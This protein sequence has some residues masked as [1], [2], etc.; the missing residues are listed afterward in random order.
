[1]RKFLYPL[2]ENPYRPK[3]IKSAI[4]VLKSCKLTSGKITENFQ[5]TF[6]KKI[7]SKHSL[8]VNSGSSANLL[9]FQCLINPYRKKKLKKGDEVIISALCWSTSLWPIIQ[10][11]LKPVFV[12]ID[13][14]TLNF[15][16]IELEKKITKKTKAIMA[17]HVLGNCTNMS[18]LIKIKNKYNL[19]L[20]E[21]TCESLGTRY[22]N[23]YLGTYGEFSSFSF[24]ASHQISSCEGGMICCKDKADYEIIKSLRAHGWSRGLSNENKIA[25]QNKDLDKRFIFFNSGFNLRSTDIAASIGLSQFKDLDKFIESRNNLRKKIIIEIKKNK[26]LKNVIQIIEQN[27]NVEASWFG[28]PILLSKKINKKNFLAN[29]ESSGV[30]TRP[31]ISGNFLKQPAIKK[32]KLH[33]KTT[34]KNADYI[35]DHGFFIGLPNNNYTLLKI[36]KLVKIFEK[37]IR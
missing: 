31:I 27:T 1:M 7:D 9:A 4:S 36:K 2:V 28:I 18:K 23:K 24:Y 30:E 34:M 8:F 17:V 37:S 10:S 26:K 32:Y 35:N 12:D 11:G 14:N 20:I 33:Y 15:D 6:T 29:L 13:R 16:L 5:N 19:L 25:K 3:D 22:K 21:D